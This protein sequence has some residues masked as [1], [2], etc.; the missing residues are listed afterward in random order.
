MPFRVKVP[1][2]KLSTIV[3]HQAAVQICGKVYY[4]T[5]KTFRCAKNSETFIHFTKI[6]AVTWSINNIIPVPIALDSCSIFFCF[7]LQ[8]FQ[9]PR[10][11]MVE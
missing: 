2:Q 11:S 7:K 5:K 9:L 10:T 3:L 6:T 4:L 1:D 8:P